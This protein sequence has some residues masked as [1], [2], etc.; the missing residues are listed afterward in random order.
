MTG[1]PPV[2]REYPYQTRWRSILFG[3]SFFGAC[4]AFFAVR[5]GNNTRG[6][7]IEDAITLGPEGA[8]TFYWVLF[9]L[10]TC[11]VLA[12]VVLAVHRVTAA[13]Q[14]LRFGATEMT[15]PAS[16][17]SRAVKTIAYRDVQSLTEQVVSGQRMLHLRHTGGK[18]TIVASL[19]PSTAAYDEVR[20]RLG[21]AV[22][23]GTDR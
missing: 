12:A 14:R 13:P 22:R 3:G 18:Y 10:S 23:S 17:W 7:I 20:A 9:A 15:V 4:A 5:A 16:R 21:S 1:E 2:D 19:L 11:F 6:V 8:T